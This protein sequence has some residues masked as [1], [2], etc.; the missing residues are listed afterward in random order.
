M[1]NVVDEYTREALAIRVG[2]RCDADTVVGVVEQ[3]VAV[4]GSASASAHG[5]RPGEDRLGAAGLVPPG[6]L[7]IEGQA[8]RRIA[9]GD[10]R[11]DG[12]DVFSVPC[13][14]CGAPPG[15]THR[16]SCTLAPGRAYRRPVECRDCRVAVGHLHVGDC[17]IEQCPRCG[18]QYQT[19][20]CVGSDDGE[21]SDD[22]DER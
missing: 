21:D 18:G 15:G 2:R 13:H 16:S 20:A 10:E 5:Q 6:H 9:Y 7:V 17:G 4:L 19:C 3:L 22:Q 1:L 8:F 11:S 14:V 12:V